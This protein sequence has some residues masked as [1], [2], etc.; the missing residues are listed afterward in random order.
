LIDAGGVTFRFNLETAMKQSNKLLIAIATL[1]LALGAPPALAS[2]IAVNLGKVSIDIGFGPPLQRYEPVP[3]PRYGH[4]WAPGY[5]QVVGHRHE[6]VPGRWIEARRGHAWIADRW[7]PVGHRWRHE[8]GHWERHG[9]T[10]DARTR[11]DSDT[12]RSHENGQRF[13]HD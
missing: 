10:P 2:E 13:R 8:P 5:W 4:L 1:G 3:P 12:R 7:T 6:W 11:H 9:S